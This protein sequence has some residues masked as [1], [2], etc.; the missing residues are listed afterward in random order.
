[1]SEEKQ[2]KEKLIEKTQ[3]HKSTGPDSTLAQREF[4]SKNLNGGPYSKHDRE[5]RIDEVSKLHFEYGYSAKKISEL[6]GVNRN[7][8]NEDIK[9]LY[10]ELEE[11][12]ENS[13]KLSL[14][15]NNIESLLAQKRRL[16]E[17]L[18]KAEKI[19]EKLAI[20]KMILQVESR[21]NQ[22]QLR[23]GQFGICKSI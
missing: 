17:A 18:D 11:K 5:D 22:F 1:M 15:Q 20:E 13:S 7:T 2:F 6:L 8:I 9:K 4:K 10:N 23:K 12:W 16:R 3:I 19:S 14:L 21:I